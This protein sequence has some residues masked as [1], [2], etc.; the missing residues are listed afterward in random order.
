LQNVKRN[1]K[2]PYPILENAKLKPAIIY[3]NRPKESAFKK[4]KII[5]SVIPDSRSFLF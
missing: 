5:A 1:Y 3:R 4:Q 2:K